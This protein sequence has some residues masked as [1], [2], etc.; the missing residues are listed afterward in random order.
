MK[1]LLPLICLFTLQG[2]SQP[3]GDIT[4]G[5]IDSIHSHIL[6]EKRNIWVHLPRDGNSPFFRSQRYPVVYLLDGDAH[7]PSVMGMIQQL[8]EVNGNTVFPEMILVGIPNTDRGRDLSPTHVKMTFYG[9]SNGVRNSGGGENFT[10]FI[11]KELIPHIDS[12]YPT[13]SYRIL[14]GH[15]L[16]GLM[17]INTLI[18]HPH[19][20]S[21]YLAID[22]S[23]WW[24]DQR[25]LKQA[26]TDLG[27]EKFSGKTLWLAVA[28]TMPAGMDTARVRKDT[29]NSTL[30]IR[31]ILQ[32]AAALK[33]NKSNGLRWSWKY[34]D[35]DSHGTVPLI[36]EYDGLRYMFDY[37]NFRFERALDNDFSADSAT[38]LFKDHYRLISQKMGYT[39]LPPEELVNMLGY[40]FL[41]RSQPGK[42][43]AFF[44]MNTE[45]YPK[46]A[47]TFDSLGDL[48]SETGDR[49]KAIQAYT[50]ALSLSDNPDTRKKLEEQKAK[51]PGPAQ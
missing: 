38:A 32:L 44:K 2:Y 27:R 45:N 1:L 21:A 24:D 46:S 50:Q 20:F 14:I 11:E 17:V 13:S 29:S 41:Q 9:D 16:G 42:S 3:G 48:Y 31:S 33:K 35:G 15:S 12:L 36:S 51:K 26:E 18:N 19:L 43:A 5:K 37:Y 7:F 22:P 34:Y 40:T 23:M 49:E 30:H 25:L 39:V 4:I 6:N 8:T 28:N 47:N 10:A